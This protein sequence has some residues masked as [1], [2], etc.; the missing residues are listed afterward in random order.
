[1]EADGPGRGKSLCTGADT[2]NVSCW[3]ML[4]LRVCGEKRLTPTGL[5]KPGTCPSL[6]A[7]G[8]HGKVLS[9]KGA[10]SD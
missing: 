10:K 6:R 3:E 4:E 2:G 8:S 7:T 9:G 5:G 1:M